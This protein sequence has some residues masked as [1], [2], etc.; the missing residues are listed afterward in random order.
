MSGVEDPSFTIIG[1]KTFVCGVLLSGEK[2]L[3]YRM[4]GYSMLRIT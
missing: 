1:K 3:E 2:A 4:F